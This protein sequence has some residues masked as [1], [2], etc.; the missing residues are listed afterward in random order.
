MSE[1]DVVAILDALAGLRLALDGGW[2]VDALVGG[3]TR[4]HRDLDFTLDTYDLS[5]AKDRL[6][7][8]GYREVQEGWV[9]RPTRVSF[10]DGRGRWLDIHP[11][12]FDD[13]GDGWQTLPGGELACYPAREFTSG[14]IAGR[15]IPCISARLQVAHHEGY[16]LA[17]HDRVDL[18][19]LE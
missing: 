10:H 11:L 5:E 3:Q 13:G 14:T 15:T 9:G 18:S 7:W 4:P 6:R 16:T 12:A 8:L 17:A 1:A 2:G 19:R